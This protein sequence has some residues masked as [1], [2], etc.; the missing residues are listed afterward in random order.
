MVD[1]ALFKSL[2]FLCAGAIVHMTGG[3]KLSEMGGLGRRYPLLAGAF[4]VGVLAIAGIAPMNGYV[5]LGL[6]HQ[7][8]LSSQNDVAYA[9]MLLAQALTIGATDVV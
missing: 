4:T 8:L 1:H 9:L 7:S 6:I 2:L 5:S 3:T